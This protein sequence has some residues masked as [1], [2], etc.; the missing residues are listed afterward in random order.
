MGA[1]SEMM[2]MI[3]ASPKTVVAALNG[4]ALGGGGEA[5]SRRKVSAGV[6]SRLLGVERTRCSLRGVLCY[7]YGVLVC[8]HGVLVEFCLYFIGSSWFSGSFS[9]LCWG[10]I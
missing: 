7:P 2:D 10:F 6:W 4:P 5:R 9:F 3:D 8:F 1:L